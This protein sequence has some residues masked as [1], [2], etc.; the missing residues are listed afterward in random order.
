M[1]WLGGERLEEQDDG[2]QIKKPKER[3]QRENEKGER[4]S[5]MNEEKETKNK[6]R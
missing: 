3:G 2:D 4:E 5:E 6:K 1:W